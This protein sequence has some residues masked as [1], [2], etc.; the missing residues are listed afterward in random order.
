MSCQVRPIR[1]ARAACAVSDAP[2]LPVRTDLPHEDPPIPPEYR[3]DDEYNREGQ[4]N[5]VPPYNPEASEFWPSQPFALVD[6][7]WTRLRSPHEYDRAFNDIEVQIQEQR[8]WIDNTY[9]VRDKPPP[10]RVHSGLYAGRASL[11]VERLSKIVFLVRRKIA[12]ML[13]RGDDNCDPVGL[14]AQQAR[15]AGVQAELE[16][17]TEAQRWHPMT[18]FDF[19]FEASDEEKAAYALA[20]QEQ[21]ALLPPPTIVTY[22]RFVDRVLAQ[23]NWFPEPLEP[24]EPMVPSARLSA[25]GVADMLLVWQPSLLPLGAEDVASAM[26]DM[27]LDEPPPALDPPAAA[28]EPA[29]AEEPTAAEETAE[30]E[31]PEQTLEEKW[32]CEP[33]DLAGVE[34]KIAAFI[35]TIERRIHA[36]D[37][38][39]DASMQALKVARGKL[40]D[41]EF[42]LRMELGDDYPRHL[43]ERPMMRF[44]AA[45]MGGAEAYKRFSEEDPVAWRAAVEAGKIAFLLQ[46]EAELGY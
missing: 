31:E 34:A 37:A 16:V 44:I 35:H 32:G 43:F 19:T 5:F 21:K 2:A 45:S 22:D 27:A 42:I 4:F 18:K 40:K 15:L 33:G 29:P 9:K 38:R 13:Y 41:E 12:V 28:E 1:A 6:G 17:A 46:Q 25:A 3:A 36:A 39:I 8:D 26:E 11:T 7:Y 14:A 10:M 23:P 20:M 24:G 30:P